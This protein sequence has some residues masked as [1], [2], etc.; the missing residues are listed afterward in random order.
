MSSLKTYTG[1]GLVF[2][3]PTDWTLS[4]DEA[5][6]EVTVSLQTPS[7]AFWS[8]TAFADRPAAEDVLGAVLTAYRDEYPEIDVYGVSAT[9]CQ[10]PAEAC[11]LDFVCLDLVSSAALRSFESLS[12]TFLIVYQGLDQELERFRG[13]FE[14]TISSLSLDS[15]EL[16]SPSELTDAPDED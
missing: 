5:D 14:R 6:G 8:L 9:V 13:D 2:Q 1:H 16:E 15:D 11:D 4:E 3:Y 7:A 12:R 10:L